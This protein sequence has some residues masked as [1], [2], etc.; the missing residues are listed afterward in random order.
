MGPAKNAQA[1]RQGQ[2]P[3]RKTPIQLRALCGLFM[4]V[5][6]ASVVLFA[7]NVSWFL[8]YDFIA[9]LFMGYFHVVAAA[10]PA[11]FLTGCWYL[12]RFIGRRS[13]PRED[14]IGDAKTVILT[15]PA[16]LV[17]AS[18]VL[19]ADDA[20]DWQ[21]LTEP[22]TWISIVAAAVGLFIVSCWLTIPA[23]IFAARLLQR[24]FGDRF[25]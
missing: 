4:L 21:S 6:V 1:S 5:A 18:L 7:F 16:F 10:A 3:A 12:P 13:S 8:P 11:A 19:A 15:Y 17:P 24:L 14:G 2:E 9:L 20:L 25:D 22:E 23:G